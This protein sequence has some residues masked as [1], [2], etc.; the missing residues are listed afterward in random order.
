MN[1][2]ESRIQQ[3][4]IMAVQRQT[5]GI[6]FSVP[7]ETK[8]RKELMKKKQTG[9][10]GGV[11][12]LIYTGPNKTMI[13]FEVKTPTGTQ[14]DNQIRFQKNM[15]NFGLDYYVVRSVQETLDWIQIH[16]PVTKENR[17]AYIEAL[18]RTLDTHGKG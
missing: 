8:D 7:N 17:G 16:T 2:S 9:L 13:F 4:I 12:D 6:I 5:P 15:E 3:Q 11:A 10:L 18:T 1:E 14:Q